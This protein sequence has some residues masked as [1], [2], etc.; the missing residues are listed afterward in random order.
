[1]EKGVMDYQENEDCIAVCLGC[2]SFCNH[3]A[4]W[5]I[6]VETHRVEIKKCIELSLECAA[7]C[8]TTA[9]LIG[10]GSDRAKELCRLCAESC[11]ECAALCSRFRDGQLTACAELC[12]KCAAACRTLLAH[13]ENIAPDA[14]DLWI[15]LN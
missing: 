11:S 7:L 2:A 1:M 10:M 14:D 8:A 13:Q 5:C 4:L 3:T 15:G 9:Q 6:D 12:R